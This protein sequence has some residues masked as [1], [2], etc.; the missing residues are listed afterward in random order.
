VTSLTL[1]TLWSGAGGPTPFSAHG[2]N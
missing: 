2:W 1:H